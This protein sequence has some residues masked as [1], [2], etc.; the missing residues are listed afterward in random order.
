MNILFIDT[1]DNKRVTAK[2][3]KD[4][5][6][7]ESFSKSETHHPESILKLI[8]EVCK[9]AEISVQNV[10][11]INVEEGPGS[12]TGLKIGTTVANA[13]S[14]A[15]QKKVNGKARGEFVMPKY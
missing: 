9:K 12:Y 5:R 6:E 1:K 8:D 11:E 4:G 2:L 13:L 10:D 3:Q 14:F 15:L 7:F